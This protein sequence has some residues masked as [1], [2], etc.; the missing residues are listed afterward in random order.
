MKIVNE[1]VKTRF[2]ELNLFIS[3]AQMAFAI[4]S[5]LKT[6]EDEFK[7]DRVGKA[8]KQDNPN[9]GFQMYPGGQSGTGTV[10]KYLTP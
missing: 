8:L 1:Q 3:L 4:G 6:I 9:G 5:S 2:I 10:Q 7:T